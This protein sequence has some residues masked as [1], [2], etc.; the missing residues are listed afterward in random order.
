[1]YGMTSGPPLVDHSHSR[2]VAV[3]LQIVET[4]IELRLIP[5]SKYSALV[6]QA[7]SHLLDSTSH[8][9][10]QTNFLDTFWY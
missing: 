3:L 9:I 8:A 5:A 10:H 7:S 2:P 1:M 4:P 6:K